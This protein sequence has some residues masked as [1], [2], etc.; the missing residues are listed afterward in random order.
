MTSEHLVYEAHGAIA[1]VTLRES[2]GPA[3]ST[4]NVWAALRS[5]FVAIEASDTVRAALISGAVGAFAFDPSPEASALP[6][7]LEGVGVQDAL[8]VLR[9]SRVPVV[10]ALRGRVSGAGALLGFSGDWIVVD[11]EVEFMALDQVLQQAAG[12]NPGFVFLPALD[13]AVVSAS[14]VLSGDE[15]ARRG[16][17]TECVESGAARERA[18]AIVKRL[19]Q[20]PTRALALTRQLLDESANADFEAQCRREL[21]VNQ[22]LRTSRDSAEGV[23]AFLEKRPARFRGE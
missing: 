2:A 12:L 19:A 9:M 20:G 18:E 1:R 22:V 16:L 8:S 11:D 21:E 17:V 4:G 10:V 6:D 5:A 23:Q 15:A 14:A 7:R 13:T 3:G